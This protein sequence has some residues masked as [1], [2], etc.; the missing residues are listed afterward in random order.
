MSFSTRKW[1]K[2]LSE[3]KKPQ[4]EKLINEAEQAEVDELIEYI[5]AYDPEESPFDDIFKD[6]WRL[7]VPFGDTPASEIFETLEDEGYEISWEPKQITVK[8]TTPNG[9]KKTR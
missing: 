8:Y 9:E 7:A 2:Y 5:E 4:E 6:K 3:D 1:F